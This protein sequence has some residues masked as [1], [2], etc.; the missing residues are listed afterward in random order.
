MVSSMTARQQAITRAAARYKFSTLVLA[1]LLFPFQLIGWAAAIVWL[2]V[3]L[4]W[5]AVAVSFTEL[6]TRARR[7]DHG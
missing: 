4:A 2:V 6:N 1:V 3:S 7:S 5:A